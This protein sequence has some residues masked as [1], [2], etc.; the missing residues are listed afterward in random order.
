MDH[1]CFALPILPGRTDDAQ[2]FHRELGGARKSDYATSEQRIGID[3]EYWFLQRTPQ[4]DMLLAYVESA[5]FATALGQFAQSQD[6][7]DQWF[8]K[9]LAAVTGVDLNNPPPG[10]LSELVPSYSSR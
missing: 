9:R 6:E 3:K 5:D 2:T 4:G 1:I 8:K 10:P 7:F